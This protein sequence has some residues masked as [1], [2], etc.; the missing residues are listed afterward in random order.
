MTPAQ[1]M[2]FTLLIALGGASTVFAAPLTTDP[3]PLFGTGSVSQAIFVFADAGDRSELTLAGFGSNPIFD[4]SVNTS[5]DAVNLG[6]LSGPQVFGLNDLTTGTGFLANV[7]DSSGFYH[8][9]YTSNY[10]D[11]GVGA[12]T[13]AVANVI[14]ALAGGSSVTF[15]GWEDRSGSQGS[16]FDY[17]DLI[18]AF[19][20]V[21]FTSTGP[22][23]TVPEPATV[24]LLSVAF[25]ALRLLRRRR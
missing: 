21:S 1:R 13:P 15:V 7:A 22:L 11:F 17:N 8:A 4:N 18:L 20:N 16:D 19:T 23:S 2:L 6:T 10:A 5:G 25:V 14:A 3:G 12:L 24:A 9:L